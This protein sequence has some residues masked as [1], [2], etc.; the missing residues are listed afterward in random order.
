MWR[1]CA[2][3]AGA[4]RALALDDRGTLGPGM[5][6]DLQVWDVATHQELVYKVGR[7]AVTTVIK[8]GRV[9]GDNRWGNA[10]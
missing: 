9:R 7:N 6:A 5:L 1:C 8:G 2:A 4:A 3:T 10:P